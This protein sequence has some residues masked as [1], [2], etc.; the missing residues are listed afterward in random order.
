[1]E[2]QENKEERIPLRVSENP[3]GCAADPSLMCV[4][5]HTHPGPAPGQRCHGG[6]SRG[7]GSRG[8]GA[9]SDAP[10]LAPARFKLTAP[11]KELR[12]LALLPLYLI[13]VFICNPITS[14]NQ[15]RG[16]REGEFEEVLNGL[17]NHFILFLKLCCSMQ[18]QLNPNPAITQS[19]GSC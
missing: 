9:V 15:L 19:I 2:G 18:L 10:A 8:T 14:Q 16:G 5:V 6:P 11:G 13:G 3:A 7:S 12:R 17:Q 4:H 1:M